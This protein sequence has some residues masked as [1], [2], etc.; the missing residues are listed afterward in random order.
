MKIL[1][2]TSFEQNPKMLENLFATGH[3]PFTHT[4]ATDKWKTEFPRIL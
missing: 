3:R 1:I 4:Q 2:M